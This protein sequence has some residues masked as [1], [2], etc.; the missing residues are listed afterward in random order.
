MFSIFSKSNETSGQSKVDAEQF[1]HGYP[2]LSENQ[3]QQEFVVEE[4]E[5]VETDNPNR[6]DEVVAL[7]KQILRARNVG[8]L[9]QQFVELS[10]EVARDRA[11][12]ESLGQVAKAELLA[13]I[14]QENDLADATNKVHQFEDENNRLKR[15]VEEIKI[16]LLTAKESDEQSK[17]SLTEAREVIFN[18]R[19]SSKRA[20]DGFKETMAEN[21]RYKVDLAEKEDEC[22]VLQNKLETVTSQKNGFSFELDSMSKYVKEVEAE[23]KEKDLSTENLNERNRLLSNEMASFNAKYISLKEKHTKLEAAMAASQDEAA[24]LRRHGDMAERKHENEVYSLKTEIDNL[25]SQL[26]LSKNSFRELS[27]EASILKDKDIKR[28]NQMVAVEAELG[29]VRSQKE[30]YS[31]EVEE[32]NAKL[33]EINLKYDSAMI[34]LQKEQDQNRDLSA[35]VS[36]IKDELSRA[37][38]TRIRYDH[39]V[40]QIEQLKSLINEY[41]ISAPKVQDN[42]AAV[43]DAPSGKKDKNESN[44]VVVKS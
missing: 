27:T 4:Q 42:P 30:R 9:A 32:L 14:K 31:R 43:G 1:E 34:D 41:R 13:K 16:E 8:N 20:A 21:E 25:M 18:I 38:S 19:S 7:E 44:L 33:R 15:E 11:A 37:E 26:R 3:Q 2:G 5:V 12:I 28:S 39:A 23:L 24:G 36:R 6:R 10:A 22:N 29:E 17:Q 40:E 35:Q